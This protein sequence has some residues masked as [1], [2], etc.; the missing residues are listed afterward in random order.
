MPLNGDKDR[1]SKRIEF[2][3]KKFVSRL[4]VLGTN[5]YQAG[6]KVLK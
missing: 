4:N 2:V 3:S 5:L 6:N 1:I